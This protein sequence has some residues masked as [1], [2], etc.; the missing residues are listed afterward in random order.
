MK[1]ENESLDKF[2][3]LEPVMAWPHIIIAPFCLK[4]RKYVRG[5][6]IGGT[7][8]RLPRLAYAMIADSPVPRMLAMAIVALITQ[9][10]ATIGLVIGT[11]VS[12]LAYPF[13]YVSRG[14]EIAAES[15]H[16]HEL[17]MASLPHAAEDSPETKS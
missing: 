6:M 2:N 8:A 12:L 1:D 9:L 15:N 3:I 4:R 13:G 5:K 10:L 17:A 7:L 16:Y 11:F 14:Y